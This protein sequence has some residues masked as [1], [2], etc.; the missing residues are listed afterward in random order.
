MLRVIGTGRL[1]RAESHGEAVSR[2]AVPRIHV[3]S[4]ERER[5]ER[6]QERR[7]KR[8]ERGE[9]REERGEIGVRGGIGGREEKRREKNRE[10]TCDLK[11]SWVK[12]M[13]FLKD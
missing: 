3:V 10:E 12:S 5:G 13:L 2:K 9:R 6:R 11:F 4:W 1:H 7:E 8:E